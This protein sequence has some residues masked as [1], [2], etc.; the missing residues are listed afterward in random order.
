MTTLASLFILATTSFNLPTGLL[1]SIC[2]IESGHDINAIHHDDGTTD[3]LGVCQVQLPT[4]R[5]VGF[6]GTAKELMK[7]EVNTIVAAAYLKHQIDRYNGD[8]KRAVISYNIGS[9]KDLTSTKYQIKVYRHWEKNRMAFKAGDFVVCA[10]VVHFLD[11]D[12]V[13]T[14]EIAGRDADGPDF[15]LLR[16]VGEE[17]WH[18]AAKF[19]LHEHWMRLGHCPPVSG[20]LDHSVIEFKGYPPIV[21]HVDEPPTRASKNDDEK[22]DLSLIP[23]ISQIEQAKALMVGE[24]KYG[25]YNYCKGHKASQLVAAAERHLKAWFDGE[26][27]DSKDGQHH[28][29][30]VMACCSMILRQEELGTL[31]DD[32][33]KK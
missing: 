27:H 2:F 32:R 5:T 16:L 31:K 26:N 22:A 17:G 11:Y 23:Y 6:K 30:S 8:I 19:K 28:L 4:A 15:Q 7:P 33:Y 25:R 10:E 12:K 29:G 20:T 13:Y 14:V 3:S 1:S 21:N 18:S 24:K 9:A